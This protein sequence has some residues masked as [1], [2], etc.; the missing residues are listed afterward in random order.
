[1]LSAWLHHRARWMVEIA[2]S[3]GSG[4]K[5]ALAARLMDGARLP[6]AWLPI[7][8]AFGRL[9]RRAEF[10]NLL[11]NFLVGTLRYA[12]LEESLRQAG[13][14]LV[15]DVGVNV[16]IT[17]RWWMSLNPRTRVVAVDM[18]EESHAFA[19]AAL[20][21]LDARYAA[22]MTPVVAVV[23]DAPGSI[24]I[25]FD[26]PLEGTNSSEAHGGLIRRQLAVR[27]LDDIWGEAGAGD[28]FL[29]KIDIEGAG[30]RALDGAAQL[31]RRTRYVVAEWHSAD[32][33][34]RM[35]TACV[36]ASLS[37]VSVNEKMVFFERR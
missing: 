3:L 19:A 17:I 32:E 26:D 23:S 2:A 34:A 37:L 4:G 30:A 22:Q 10:E 6:V 21:R 20:S 12:P 28:V 36:S 14:P 8:P 29:L 25:S 27:T 9:T 7:L 13:T 18:I 5:R 15:V 16:G 33:L 24:E 1:M 31:L 11:D 35:T